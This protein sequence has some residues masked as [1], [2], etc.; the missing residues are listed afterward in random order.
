MAGGVR[1][2]EKPSFA[3]GTSNARRRLIDKLVVGEGARH[4]ERKR[5]AAARRQRMDQRAAARLN[6]STISS[7]SSSSSNSSSSSSGGGKGYMHSQVDDNEA[8]LH[9]D[10]SVDATVSPADVSSATVRSTGRF[11]TRIARS[12]RHVTAASSSSPD[13]RNQQPSSSSPYSPASAT[14]AKSGFAESESARLIAASRAKRAAA[15]SVRQASVV[16]H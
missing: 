6:A 4:E 5:R 15:R 12:S 1:S 10:N 9:D 2:A 7:S 16:S 8:T 3:Q 13:K 11:S 14:T